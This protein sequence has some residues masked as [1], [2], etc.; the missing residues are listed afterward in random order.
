MAII[1]GTLSLRQVLQGQEIPRPPC[2]ND[3]GH[4][5]ARNGTFQ[6]GVQ[7]GRG[8][9]RLTIQRYRCRTCSLTFSVLPYDCRPFANHAWSLVLAVGWVWREEHGWTW[10]KCQQWLAAHHLELH[11][12][13]V[14]RWAA[15]WRAGAARVITT[16]I[17]WIAEHF[18]TREVSVWQ[19][20]D[21]SVLTH[22]RVLWK[23]VV[24]IDPGRSLY[25]GWVAASTLWGWIPVT[26]FAGM[27]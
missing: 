7:D 18:G 27:A 6:R 15:R 13:T 23:A 4:V 17:R 12:R 20:P 8:A 11:Q 26:F 10:A 9:Y 21:P 14:E 25:G 24:A 19:G 22:W 5:L 2:A 1:Y 16:A 3:V